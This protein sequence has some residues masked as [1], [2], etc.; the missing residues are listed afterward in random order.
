MVW[1]NRWLV[2][3]TNNPLHSIGEMKEREVPIKMEMLSPYHAI[4]T[5]L[6]FLFYCRA[7]LQSSLLSV[8]NPFHRPS[9]LPSS[10]LIL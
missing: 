1:M 10:P 7:L 3:V 4:S 6:E 2:R 9:T 8:C 5:L